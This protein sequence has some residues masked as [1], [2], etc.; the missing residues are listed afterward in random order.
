MKADTAELL[1][2]LALRMSDDLN[3]IVRDIQASEPESE[4][5][6][7]RQAINRVMWAIYFDILKPAFEEHPWLEREPGTHAA[8]KLGP[9]PRTPRAA[10]R[11]A[12]TPTQGA[13]RP[14]QPRGSRR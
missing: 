7:L 8:M 2:A 5:V 1:T 3:E 9:N 6:R 14:R 11:V 13:R 12:R 10:G 4:M